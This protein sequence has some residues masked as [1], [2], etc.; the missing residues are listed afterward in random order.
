MIIV[1]LKFIACIVIILFAGRNVAKYG[2]II[3]SKTGLGGLWI[4]VL[5][6]A[7]ATSLPELFT[8]IS[9]VAILKAPD[10]AIGDLFGAN[11]FNLFNLALLDIAY[12]KKPILSEANPRHTLAASLS[13]IM[14]A[15]PAVCLF[16]GPMLD[17]VK[18]GYIGIYTP[19]ILILYI[20]II[21]MIFKFEKD[22]KTEQE[23]NETFYDENIT[24][25]LRRAYIYYGISAVIIIAAGIWLA[26]VGKEVSLITGWEQSFVGSLFLAFTTTLPEITVSFA[27]LRL[28]AIDIC[29]ANMIGSNI[30][31][32]AII[33]VTDIFYFNGPILSHVSTSHIFTAMSVIIMSGIV[34]AGLTSRSKGRK[35]L[36]VSWHAPMLVLV[37]LLTAYI[38]FVI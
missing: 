22:A 3:A 5:I 33:F 19:I 27:A 11:A 17:V 1:W 20:A 31:N 8:G 36:F 26:F 10:L 16:L 37:F 4:G 21:R 9:S 35:P 30:F 34:I 24:I 14:I 13:I 15:F 6:V 38:N 28:G 23:D 25:S 12:R 2:D 32:M 7:I 29:V 18:L